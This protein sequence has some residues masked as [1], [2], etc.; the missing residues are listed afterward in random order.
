MLCNHTLISETML[1]NNNEEREVSE[2]TSLTKYDVIEE[3]S[4]INSKDMVKANK[5]ISLGEEGLINEKVD[6]ENKSFS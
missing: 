3:E 2:E 1:K 6:E 4:E 5:E